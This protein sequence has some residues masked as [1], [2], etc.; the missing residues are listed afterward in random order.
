VA[1]PE[2]ICQKH[3]SLPGE[4]LFFDGYPEK[5][6]KSLY[7]NLISRATRLMAQERPD[8]PIPAPYP[9]YFLLNY[10]PGKTQ[11]VNKPGAP[12]DYVSSH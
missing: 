9:N 10:S 3:Q 5:C 7:R 11:S 2:R 1:P 8:L 6:S 12:C 4:L